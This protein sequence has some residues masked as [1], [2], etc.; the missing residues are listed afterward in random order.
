MPQPATKPRDIAAIA[1]AVAA[2]GLA[3]GAL[4]TANGLSVWQVAAMSLFVFAGGSQFAFVG[5]LAAGGSP[6]SAAVPGLLLNSRLAAFGLLVRP[7]LHGGWLRRLLGTHL[8]SDEN[9]AMAVAAPP[10]ERASRLLA[11]E[12]R[13]LRGLEHQH[14]PWRGRGCAIDP[15]ALGLDVAFPATFVALLVPLLRQPGA[16]TAAA[17]GFVVAVGMTPFLPPGI[18]ISLA[19]VG[20]GAGLSQRGGRRGIPED[21][22]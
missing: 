20:A 13:D 14:H 1:L 9:T 12:R 3:F 18:P 6:L 21:V 11:R 10:A 19:V 22:P 15:A 7:L 2:Y 8:M 5:V 16:V 4:A 17:V